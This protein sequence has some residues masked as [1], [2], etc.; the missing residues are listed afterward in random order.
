MKKT[1]IKNIKELEIHAAEN[2]PNMIP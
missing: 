2:R 1:G